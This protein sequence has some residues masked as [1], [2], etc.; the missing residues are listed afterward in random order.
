MHPHFYRITGCL[1]IYFAVCSSALSYAQTFDISKADSLL[2]AERV[3]K[4]ECSAEKKCL[5]EWNAGEDFLSLGMEHFIWFPDNS[6]SI[7]KDSFRPFLKFAKKAGEHLPAVLDK[8]PFPSCPWVSRK[9]F[10]MSKESPEYKDILDFMIKTKDCQADY[11]IKTTKRSLRKIINAVPANQRLRITKYLSELTSNAQGLYAI[12]DYIN[13]KG[14][15]TGSNERYQ[16]EGWGLLQVLQGMHDTPNSKEALA[17]FV[18][19]ARDVLNHRVFNSPNG[20]H[21]EKWLQGWLRRTNTY[22][23]IEKNVEPPK[24]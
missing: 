14:S 7:F 18:R 3:S 4:N 15:G 24:E 11:L 12:I 10:L 17:E 1:V 9:Q 16:G 8:T 20:R 19:S 22:L 13:F 5:L 6:P 21:E 23:I 2:M